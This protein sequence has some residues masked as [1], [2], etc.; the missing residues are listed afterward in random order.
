MA[1]TTKKPTIP[2]QPIGL[3]NTTWPCEGPRCRLHPPV[4]GLGLKIR[5]VRAKRLP[6]E[7]SSSQPPLPRSL[8]HVTEPVLLTRGSPA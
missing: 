7:P 2:Q 3:G 6:C 1:K 5:T 4:I 8:T